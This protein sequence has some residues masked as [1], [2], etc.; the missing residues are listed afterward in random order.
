MTGVFWKDV[1]KLVHLQNYK[2]LKGLNK[3][4]FMKMLLKKEK[5]MKD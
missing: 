4:N 2:I 3:K 1:E 5:E